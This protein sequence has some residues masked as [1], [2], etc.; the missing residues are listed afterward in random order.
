MQFQMIQEDKKMHKFRH[1]QSESVDDLWSLIHKQIRLLI[2]VS[3]N[4]LEDAGVFH[5]LL[6]KIP[7][8]NAIFFTMKETTISITFKDLSCCNVKT[9][10][11]LLFT[12]L[13]VMRQDIVVFSLSFFCIYCLLFCP[14]Q[15]GGSG[16]PFVIANPKSSLDTGYPYT[17]SNLL[18]QS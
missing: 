8:T 7:M 11:I 12:V 4:A 16:L 10:I 9:F 5:M 1:P 3:F 17:T 15:L 18:Y 14:V 13:E 2:S 6:M